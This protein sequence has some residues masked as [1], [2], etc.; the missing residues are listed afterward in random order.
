MGSTVSSV[1]K[2][3]EGKSFDAAVTV[4]WAGISATQMEDEVLYK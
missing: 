2:R 4:R 3:K 1:Q